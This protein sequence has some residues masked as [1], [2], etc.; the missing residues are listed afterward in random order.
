M[1]AVELIQQALQ[2]NL[3]KTKAGPAKSGLLAIPGVA[4]SILPFGGCPAC[5]PVYGGILSTLGLG[6]LLSTRYLFPLTTT[7]LIVTLAALAFRARTRR[8]YGPLAAGVVAG[9]LILW[10][11]FSIE[12]NTVAYSG[13][14]LLLAASAWNSW[15]RQS[16]SVL[17]HA[18]SIQVSKIEGAL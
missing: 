10:G 13:A 18:Q 1:P 9:S 5:W 14:A 12:S 8:G 6:F 11:K 15:P 4:V 3:R 17:I 2:S 16:K 7:L